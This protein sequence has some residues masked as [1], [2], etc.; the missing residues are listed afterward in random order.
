[1]YNLG[2]AGGIDYPE[3]ESY[4]YD[5]WHCTP[6][7]TDASEYKSVVFQMAQE[8]LLLHWKYAYLEIHGKLVKKADGADYETG[9]KIAPIF[10]AVPHLF[11]NAK[12]TIGTRCVENVNHVGHVS[13]LMHYVLLPR[14]L[15]K[16]AGVQYMWVQDTDATASNAN[17]GWET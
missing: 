13:S 10:N 15:S 16:E 2:A 9:A 8:N 1:M 14:S 3:T 6:G 17:K 11:S 4:S 5:T 7:Q 12:F